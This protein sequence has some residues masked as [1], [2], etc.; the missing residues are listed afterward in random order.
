MRLHA[1]YIGAELLIEGVTPPPFGPG[2]SSG[3][4][5]DAGALEVW[6]TSLEDV[7]DTTVWRLVRDRAAI[8]VSEVG[9]F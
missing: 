8:A 3:Q 7:A 9:G 6:A 2:F 4:V 5:T 1:H